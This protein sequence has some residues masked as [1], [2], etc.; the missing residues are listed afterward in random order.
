MNKDI[1]KPNYNIE[2]SKEAVDGILED[3]ADLLKFLEDPNRLGVFSNE[4]ITIS[5]LCG[6]NI[7]LELAALVN[8]LMGLKV[9]L[10]E[11]NEKE[12]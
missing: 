1:I 4:T 6:C 2:G 7:K 12:K 3:I 8:I 9:L 5:R 11:M 10:E